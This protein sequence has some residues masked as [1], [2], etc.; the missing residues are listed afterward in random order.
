MGNAQSAPHGGFT[1]EE[2]L[3]DSFTPEERKFPANWNETHQATHVHKLKVYPPMKEIRKIVRREFGR[4]AILTSDALE[5][6]FHTHMKITEK[7]K[8]AVISLG[9]GPAH[10]L[11]AIYHYS[12]A[13]E[14]S[15]C[16]HGVD[17]STGSADYINM[18]IPK[19]CFY[20]KTALEFCQQDLL[21][22]VS[23][24]NT[25]LIEISWPEVPEC[26]EPWVESAVTE[27]VRLAGEKDIRVWLLYTGLIAE[28]ET[29]ATRD[30]INLLRNNASGA[31][32][33]DYT[34]PLASALEASSTNDAHLDSV[35]LIEIGQT[36]NVGHS[37]DRVLSL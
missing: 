9:C 23:G 15:F 2:E 24:H 22:L 33:I 20:N 34:F 32:V 25:L 37:T 19:D 7:H 29:E 21:V 26:D 3:H 4:G 14:L 8:V 16:C 13:E 10:N 35:V 12:E 28:S 18:Q 30:Y 5:C 1:T 11:S 36:S 6:V 17:C 27:V 31:H